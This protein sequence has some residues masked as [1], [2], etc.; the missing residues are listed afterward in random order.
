MPAFQNGFSNPDIEVFRQGLLAQEQAELWQKYEQ[1][2]AIAETGGIVFAGDSIT[3]FFPVSE[4]LSASLPVYNRGI[5]G[6]DSQ[7]LLAHCDSQ[8]LGLQPKA[9]FLLI[10]VNDLKV[11]NP[12][13]TA[14]TVQELC[15]AIRTASP[16]TQIFL[17]S[18]YPINQS[19]HFPQKPSKRSNAAIAELNLLLAELADLTF[20]N[21][22]PH[23]LDKGGQLKAA[24][25]TDGIHL[26]VAGYCA[27]SL[28]LQPY[29]DKL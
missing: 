5:H 4:L 24:Y 9:L 15:Q 28:C 14:E 13:E 20:I 19:P 29:L 21:V 3:E 17:L 1:L 11:R 22:Y 26:T 2:N 23:L 27:V 7:Q 25:T 18:V 16:D 10:G 6:I 8:I 12:Q